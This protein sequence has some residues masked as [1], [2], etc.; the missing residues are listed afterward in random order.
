MLI[1]LEHGPTGLDQMP[2]ARQAIKHGLSFEV[3]D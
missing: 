1:L 3:M 2:T